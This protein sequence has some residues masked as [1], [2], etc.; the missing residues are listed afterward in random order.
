MGVFKLRRIITVFG[1]SIPVKGDKQYED[2]YNCAC[3]LARNNFD[4]C[5]GGN[6]GI[7]EAVSLG[8]KENGA[9]AIGVTLSGSFGTHNEY[10]TE[11][12]LCD[13]L[14]ERISRL[15]SLGHGYIILQGGTGTLLELSVIWEYM[16][17]GFMAEKPAACAGRMWTSIVDT[18]EE[19]IFLE[20]RKT[21]LIKVYPDA[22]A[23]AMYMKEYF[24][25]K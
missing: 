24:D 21:G 9:R 19:Q 22:Q 12:I 8:A 23:C 17:K 25:R 16:N 1:S 15:V 7:M 3:I 6:M 5:T 20:K 2:A 10:L 4:I 13:S 18:M 11:H 14:F